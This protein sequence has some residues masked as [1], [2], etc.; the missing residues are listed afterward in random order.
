MDDAER[1]AWKKT[2]TDEINK[3]ERQ[4][5]TAFLFGAGCGSFVTSIIIAT[6]LELIA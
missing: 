2:Y 6:I 3:M 5:T 1:T 4:K